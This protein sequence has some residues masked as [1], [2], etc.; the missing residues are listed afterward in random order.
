MFP[1]V[2]MFLFEYYFPECVSVPNKALFAE[3]HLQGKPQSKS[4]SIIQECFDA[5]HTDSK[6]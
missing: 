3:W 1:A 2:V 5:F 6:F 4:L